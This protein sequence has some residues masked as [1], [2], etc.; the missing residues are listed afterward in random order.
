MHALYEG[1][2]PIAKLLIEAGAVVHLQNND[3]DTALLTALYSVHMYNGE[4]TLKGIWT[5]E[6]PIKTGVEFITWSPDL[7]ALIFV[8]S[9]GH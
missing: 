2:F 9:G 4:G 6:F 7:R 3:G 8:T 1:Y 5:V